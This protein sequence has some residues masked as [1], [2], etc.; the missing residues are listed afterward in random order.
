MLTLVAVLSMVQ[1]ADPLGPLLE[2]GPMVLIERNANGKFVQATGV[3]AISAPPE[4]VWETLVDMGSYKAFVPK[5][6]TSV[7][8]GRE[9][10]KG[11]F[12]VRFVLEVPGPDTDYTIRY[13]Q[14]PKAMTLEGKWLAG[15]LKDSRWFWKVEPGPN[16]KTLLHHTTQVKNFSAILQNVEDD[17]QTITVGV[18][19]SAAAAITT[20]LKRRVES[21]LAQAKPADASVGPPAAK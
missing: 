18:N 11:Q 8:L 1:A 20:A 4:K 14:D 19:V 6:E 21:L 13:V 17:Q 5:V 12:D 2:R 10:S 16:G 15:D 7:I 9:E 3:V